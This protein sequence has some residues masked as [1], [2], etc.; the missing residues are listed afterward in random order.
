MKKI[1][2]NL[3][4]FTGL[5][6][7]RV[8][9]IEDPDG[10]TLIDTGLPLA[11]ARIV[12]QLT[13]IG[14]SP[15]DIKRILIT[16]AHP[17]HIGGLPGLTKLTN[18]E[19]WTSGGEAAV[20]RGEAPIA[21]PERQTV[22]W[23]QRLMTYMA[24]PSKV[25]PGTVHR[26]IKEGDT[27]EV[28]GGLQVISTPGHAPDHIS[29]LQP[30]K[31]VLFAGDVVGHLFRELNAPLRAFTVDMRQ[32]MRSVRKLAAL[33]VELQTIL[34]GHGAPLTEDAAPKLYRLAHKRKLNK[35]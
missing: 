10:L 4:T 28:M 6:A 27:L 34:C 17:D 16:H 22:P 5:M 3:Y 1:A 29:F 20:I 21:R 11:P 8:Y 12:E 23:P 32:N 25:V 13:E 14:R 9:L 26:I 33:E 24:P 18:A 19:V 2:L 15:S 35:K 31:R 7:G 30:E